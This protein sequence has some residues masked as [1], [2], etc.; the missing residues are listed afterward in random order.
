MCKI[1]DNPDIFLPHQP[2]GCSWSPNFVILHLGIFHDETIVAGENE[3]PLMI[4]VWEEWEET[5]VP[6]TPQQVLVEIEDSVAVV[7]FDT[8]EGW[9]QEGGVI[10]E[11]ADKL[12]R[13]GLVALEYKGPLEYDAEA[14]WFYCW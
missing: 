6:E 14:P 2:I 3:E 1:L 9:Y 13:R 12:V 11:E 4:P 8:L 10:D 5:I 7:A